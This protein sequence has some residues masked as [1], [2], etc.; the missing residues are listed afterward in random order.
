LGE[1]F[2]QFGELRERVRIPI[3]RYSGKLR[4]IAFASFKKGE[5]AKKAIENSGI[6]FK[7]NMLKIC[8]A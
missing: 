1:F 3:D 8:L 5:D 6:D 2:S 4:G 7:H